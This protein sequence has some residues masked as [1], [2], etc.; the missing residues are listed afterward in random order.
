MKNDKWQMENGKSSFIL[1]L[2]RLLPV[3]CCRQHRLTL[4]NKVIGKLK[5]IQIA[6]YSSSRH[7]LVVRSYVDYAPAIQHNDLVRSVDRC[8]PMRDHQ[9]RSPLH[10]V[11]ERVLN[12]TL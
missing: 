3:R 8:K 1:D 10:Q 7:Q 2:A 11:C 4:P 6:I 9:G 5:L 12:Q